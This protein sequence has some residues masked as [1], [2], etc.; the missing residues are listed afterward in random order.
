M[1]HETELNVGK[2]VPVTRAR[3]LRL[4]TFA[5]VNV[6]LVACRGQSPP[7]TSSTPSASANTVPEATTTLSGTAFRM[8]DVPSGEAARTATYHQAPML[9]ELVEAGKLPPVEQRLP[10]N[11]YVIPHVW[12]SVGTYGGEI[13]MACVDQRGWG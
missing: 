11:P 10:A 12:L 4:A 9:G 13:R 2:H 1:N 7:E 3:F 6:A 5:A 8:N